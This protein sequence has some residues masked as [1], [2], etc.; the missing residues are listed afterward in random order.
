[1]VVMAAE[2]IDF[3][4]NNSEL[5]YFHSNASYLICNYSA[6][7][8][9][10]EFNCSTFTIIK[11]PLVPATGNNCTSDQRPSIVC[12]S[13]AQGCQFVHIHPISRQR[14]LNYSGAL[15]FTSNI[16]F[17]CFPIYYITIF[18]VGS[19]FTNQNSFHF[20]LGIYLQQAVQCFPEA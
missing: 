13:V 20:S 16:I 6:R 19:L 5:G 17:L 4:L 9:Q 7:F 3:S 11:F 15:K 10:R 1:M 14:A 12:S 8:C 2:R 18:S